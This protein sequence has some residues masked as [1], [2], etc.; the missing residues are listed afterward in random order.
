LVTG[1]GFGGEFVAAADWALL[2]GYAFAGELA[3]LAGPFVMDF[4]A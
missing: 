1:P 4:A 2:G 3:F